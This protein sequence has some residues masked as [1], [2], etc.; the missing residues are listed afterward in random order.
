MIRALPK[1]S[2][3][4]LAVGATAAAVHFL[5]VWLMVRF[6]T[7]SP[8]WANVIAFWVAFCV[9]YSGHRSVT[10]AASRSPIRR[11]APR[12]MLVSIG[13]FLLNQGMY[14]ALLYLLPAVHYL[15]LLFVVTAIVTVVTYLLG[16]YWAFTAVSSS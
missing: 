11:S 2:V 5:V 12:W 14:V 8:A 4:F 1:Q 9:S 10:F 13:G 6:V 3:A 15:A 16:K 7:L